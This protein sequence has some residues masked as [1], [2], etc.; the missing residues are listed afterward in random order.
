MACDVVKDLH[1]ERVVF[2]SLTG[3][4]ATDEADEI[5]GEENDPSL[6]KV[7]RK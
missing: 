4:V 7:M 5:F 1:T 6:A 2:I 3:E